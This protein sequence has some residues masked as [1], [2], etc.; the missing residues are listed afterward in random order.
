MSATGNSR[1]WVESEQHLRGRAEYFK[2]QGDF[3]SLRTVCDELLVFVDRDNYTI[4][5]RF[6]MFGGFAVRP[7]YVPALGRCE[8]EFYFQSDWTLARLERRWPLVELVRLIA[9][10]EGY[11]HVSDH[12]AYVGVPP[13]VD[14]LLGD[15]HALSAISLLSSRTLADVSHRQLRRAWSLF[16]F[17]AE[18][19]QP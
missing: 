9:D 5:D 8:T 1:P 17:L 13:D 12:R 15:T 4:D 14:H 19:R 3:L 16:S 18:R 2:L 11:R 6:E 7:F 10:G